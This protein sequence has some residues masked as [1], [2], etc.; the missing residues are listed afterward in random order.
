MMNKLTILFIGLALMLTGLIMSGCNGSSS[1]IDPP[2]RYDYIIS[3]A[4]VIDNNLSSVHNDSTRIAVRLKRNTTALND[5]DIIF[6][7]DTLTY[8]FLSNSTSLAYSFPSNPGGLLD[9][10]SYQMRIID[11]DKFNGSITVVNPSLSS[12]MSYNPDSTT[13][14]N[15]NNYT[16]AFEWT[17]SLQVNGYIIAA[18]PVDSL[19][20]GFGFSAYVT[21][22]G[23]EDSFP[24]EAF[25]SA[26]TANVLPGN[27][28]LYVYGYTG[29]PDSALSSALLPVPLPSQLPDNIDQQYLGGHF[30]TVVVSKR[31]PLVVVDG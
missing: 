29:A 9:T 5:A 30:G 18:V 12:V 23:S 11:N 21:A 24:P 7:N 27:Y 4:L 25:R 14:Y 2:N 16:L 1:P 17:A 3:G 22:Q 15:A 31:V 28:Y 6:N 26:D 10:G 8:T 20:T 13:T 19:Y